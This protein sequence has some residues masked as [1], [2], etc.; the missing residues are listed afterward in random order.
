MQRYP[1]HLNGCVEDASH[2]CAGN[3]SEQDTIYQVVC[4]C[5][6]RLFDLLLSDKDSVVA[7]CDACK[8]RIVIYD[9]ALYPTAIKLPGIEDFSSLSVM[10][11]RPSRIFVFYEYGA[12]DDDQ[13]FDRNAITWCQVFSESISGQLVKVFDDETA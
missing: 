8:S 6:G 7:I 13:E 11:V 3:P 4:S 9:L 1:A 5:G 12:L 2:L 10:P